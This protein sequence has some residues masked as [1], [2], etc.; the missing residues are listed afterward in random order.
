MSEII[1]VR[2]DATVPS[3]LRHWP[4]PEP[5]PAPAYGQGRALKRRG[6]L[7]DQPT[8]LQLPDVRWAHG[9]ITCQPGRASQRAAGGTCPASNR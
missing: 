7:R 4:E 6:E 3:G 1:Y 2:G 9:D 5:E 8:N